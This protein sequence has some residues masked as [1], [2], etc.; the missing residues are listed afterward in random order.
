MDILNSSIDKLN[1]SKFNHLPGIKHVSEKA[2]VK[3]EYI[4]L[5]LT[6]LLTL[7]LILTRF[8]QFSLMLVVVYLYPI[9]KSF[10]AR[11]TNNQLELN[12]W[13]IYW[14]VFGFVIAISSFIESWIQISNFPL[15]LSIFFFATY[16]ALVDGQAYIYDNVMRPLL[17]KYESSIDKYIQ[18]AKDEANDIKIRAKKEFANKLAE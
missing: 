11:E 6:V 14:T 18:L 1:L 10:K 15:L 16:C 7:V 8:G 3:A 5:V 2:G 13:L 17:L 12:R 9:Y 4:T